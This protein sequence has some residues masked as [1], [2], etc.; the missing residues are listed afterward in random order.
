[1]FWTT[2]DSAIG[3]ITLCDRCALAATNLA[4]AETV[5]SMFT[6]M[7]EALTILNAAAAMCGLDDLMDVTASEE[8]PCEQCGLPGTERSTA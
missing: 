5:N 4:A 3:E 8:G 1:M 7:E 6:S 2:A